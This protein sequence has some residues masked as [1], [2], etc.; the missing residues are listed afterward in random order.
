M[1]YCIQICTNTCEVTMQVKR[2]IIK[3]ILHKLPIYYE[4]MCLCWVSTLFG[5]ICCLFSNCNKNSATRL[6]SPNNLYL[7]CKCVSFLGARIR[8]HCNEM[9]RNM[10]RCGKGLL[11]IV[12][13]FYVL[14]NVLL[15]V[16]V[17]FVCL[18]ICIS[19]LDI[20]LLTTKINKN[21]KI[22]TCFFSL[23]TYWENPI[24]I[25]SNDWTPHIFC[26]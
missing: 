23:L 1:L 22:F 17:L 18:M 26:K 21:K 5:M 9:M 13:S 7:R 20:D 15:C 6:Q 11:W 16:L 8:N 3:I 14:I 10:E 25:T 12:V 2:D 19:R 24:I 4:Y